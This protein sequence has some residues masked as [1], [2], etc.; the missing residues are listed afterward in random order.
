MIGF[1]ELCGEVNQQLSNIT[2][3]KEIIVFVQDG[4][5]W[6]FYILLVKT[7]VPQVVVN[8]ILFH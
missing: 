6:R 3:S 2:F 4:Q 8:I 5:I 7:F 1:K